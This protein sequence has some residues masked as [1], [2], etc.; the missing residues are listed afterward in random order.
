[1]WDCPFQYDTFQRYGNWKTQYSQP[2]QK[3]R[4]TLW[5]LVLNR[6]ISFCTDLCVFWFF[7]KINRAIQE[8]AMM[9]SKRDKYNHSQSESFKNRFNFK[10]WHFSLSSFWQLFSLC[11]DSFNIRKHFCLSIFLLPLMCH[12]SHKFVVCTQNQ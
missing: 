8:V 10:G 6:Q 9:H 11:F 4:W 2:L 3:T 5:G 7:F 12:F 1:M